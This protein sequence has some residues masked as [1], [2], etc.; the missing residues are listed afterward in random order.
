M[1]I[2]LLLLPRGFNLFDQYGKLEYLR[3]RGL[4]RRIYTYTS[5]QLITD[6]NVKFN[7]SETIQTQSIE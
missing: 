7:E 1:I 6:Y 3:R 5:N 4:Y 2:K